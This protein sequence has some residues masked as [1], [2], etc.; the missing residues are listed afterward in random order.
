MAKKAV[1]PTCTVISVQ[2]AF[3]IALQRNINSPA[4]QRDI[5][6]Q[7]FPELLIELQ[8]VLLQDVALL[9]RMDKYHD[10]PI[11]YHHVFDGP[12]WERFSQAVGEVCD[13]PEQPPEFVNFPPEVTIFR[14]Q[15][16]SKFC[17]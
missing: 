12:E 8:A 1:Y 4:S 3:L 5:A 14:L 7:R 11:I 9:Q 16:C 2:E 10:H 6:A 15:S 13:A 17:Y